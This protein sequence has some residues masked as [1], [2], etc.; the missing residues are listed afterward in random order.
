MNLHVPVFRN[1]GMHFSYQPIVFAESPPRSLLEQTGYSSCPARS[2]WP[3]LSVG[4]TLPSV[5]F[6]CRVSGVWCLT[7][8][9]AV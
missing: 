2:L 5:F 1:L 4:S 7:F 6:A 9:L 8:D 3:V